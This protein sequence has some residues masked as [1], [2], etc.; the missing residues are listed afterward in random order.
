[1]HPLILRDTYV[2]HLWSTGR[3]AIEHGAPSDPSQPCTPRYAATVYGH[4][5]CRY[6]GTRALRAHLGALGVR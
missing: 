2:M 4:L 5:S 3:E 1:M 6:V